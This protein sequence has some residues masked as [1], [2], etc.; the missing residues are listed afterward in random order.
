M[1]WAK[2]PNLGQTHDEVTRYH[3]HLAGPG[4]AEA[5]SVAA[6][7]PTA[8]SAESVPVNIGPRG[9][10]MP[11]EMANMWNDPDGV[12]SRLEQLA[13]PTP[14]MDIAKPVEAQPAEL[15]KPYVAPEVTDH[16]NPEENRPEYEQPDQTATAETSSSS[17]EIKPQAEWNQFAQTVGDE[18]AK[19]NDP[20]AIIEGPGAAGEGFP[21][22]TAD[23]LTQTEPVVYPGEYMREEDVDRAHSIALAIND[24]ETELVGV[25]KDATQAKE[26]WFKTSDEQGPMSPEA[27]M[28]KFEHKD[29]QSKLS[30]L[31]TISHHKEIEASKDHRREQR[32]AAEKERR[33]WLQNQRDARKSAVPQLAGP[34]AEAAGEGFP[35]ANTA[36]REGEPETRVQ[37][38]VKAEHLAY[39]D[40][41]KEQQLAEKLTDKERSAHQDYSQDIQEVAEKYPYNTS[42]YQERREK[43]QNA[44]EKWSRAGEKASAEYLA[45]RPGYVA[46]STYEAQRAVKSERVVEAAAMDSLEKNLVNTE[47]TIQRKEQ[48][49]AESVARLEK[50]LLKYP[51]GAHRQ[52]KKGYKMLVRSIDKHLEDLENQRKYVED[53]LKKLSA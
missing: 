50:E 18:N 15:P 30:K 11:K 35:G 25:R 43:E 38:P 19:E 42:S 16:G 23:P 51:P 53:E 20:H 14:V 26:N 17:T 41:E 5:E 1:D 52:L 12:G 21:G 27:A 46:P 34:G 37:D 48:E 40:Q 29:A 45:K 44:S 4:A 28:A 10:T 9:T 49:R 24:T 39:A 3:L 13:P 31:E 6:A 36:L 47:E 32:E 7:V 2:H 22:A 33:E 8:T